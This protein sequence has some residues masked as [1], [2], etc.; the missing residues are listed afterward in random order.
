M[1]SS[2]DVR[3]P[4]PQVVYDRR[5]IFWRYAK[6]WLIVDALAAFPFNFMPGLDANHGGGNHQVAYLF[7]LPKALQVYGLLATAS[8]NH[9]M[10]ET[11]FLAIRTLLSVMVV[12]AIFVSFLL[13][14]F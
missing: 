9:K 2:A 3:P 8:D 1:F 13:L 14:M 10:H 7:S 11:I 4:N 12:S 5:E 6:G